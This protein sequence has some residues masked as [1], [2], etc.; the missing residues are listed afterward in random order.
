MLPGHRVRTT[1]GRVR[2]R[3][4]GLLFG[5]PERS[6]FANEIIG[7]V[8]AGTGVVQR[9]LA[10]LESAGLV[11]VSRVDRQKHYQANDAA[12]I[13]PE[14]RGIVLKTSGLKDVLHDGLSPLQDEIRVA[15]VFGSM[16]RGSATAGSDV[17]LIVVSDRLTYAELFGTL[18]AISSRL[19]RTVNPTIY[20]SV[21]YEC[22]AGGWP[23]VWEVA[24]LRPIVG[25]PTPP[26]SHPEG[27]SCLGPHVRHGAAEGPGSPGR[28]SWT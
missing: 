23:T 14:F 19:A 4:L 8:D 12:P 24:A 10:R 25:A 9:E 16:A 5:H 17:D 26:E 22:P 28:S 3:V 15:F 21:E 7:W 6:F 2:Q 1:G 20:T 18:E 11:T 27:D 13:F